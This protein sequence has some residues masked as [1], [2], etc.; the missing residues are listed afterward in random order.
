MSNSISAGNFVT[1]Q[2][3]AKKRAVAATRNTGG[4]AAI[5]VEIAKEV[6]AAYPNLSAPERAAIFG[7]LTADA[8]SSGVDATMSL[9]NV[10][11]LLRI[12]QPA[13][14]PK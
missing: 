13:P 12:N 14:A 2:L 7:T 10:S 5:Y 1:N 8:Q 3:V 4:Y 6:L 9:R 11:R